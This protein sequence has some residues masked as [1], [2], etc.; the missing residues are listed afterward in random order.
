MDLAEKFML[1]PSNNINND[2]INYTLP[3]LS[4][5]CHLPTL[6]PFRSS[7]GRNEQDSFKQPLECFLTN[8][9]RDYSNM[10]VALLTAGG[11]IFSIG[12]R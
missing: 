10:Y 3:V 1:R 9:I 5:V 6:S 2:N 11:S 8:S 12:D 7:T 4:T